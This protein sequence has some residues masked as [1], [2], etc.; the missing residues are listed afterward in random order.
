[1]EGQCTIR[2]GCPPSSAINRGPVRRRSGACVVPQRVP[3]S[4]PVQFPG[5]KGPIHAYFPLIMRRAVL[6]ATLPA[7]LAFSVAPALSDGVA[8]CLWHDAA[9]TLTGPEQ[10]PAEHGVHHADC[11]WLRI[12]GDSRAVHTRISGTVR[13]E[14]S[15]TPAP[16]IAPC[17]FREVPSRFQGRAPP[18]IHA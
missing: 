13:L 15:G 10:G 2:M 5:P 17:V 12:A 7:L 9:I 6:I 16:S 4:A 14:A 1:M 3:C 18:S 8:H 11:Y